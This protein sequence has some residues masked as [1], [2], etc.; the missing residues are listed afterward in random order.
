MSR[1][2]RNDSGLVGLFVTGTDTGVGKT[3]VTC[4]I[5]AALRARGMDVGVYKP[6]ETGCRRDGDCLTGEDCGR[7]VAAAGHAQTVEETASYL[8]ELPAAPLVAAEAAGARIDPARIVGG[9][10]RLGHQH[11]FVLVEGA[12]GLLVPIAEGYAYLDLARELALPVVVVVGSRLGCINHALLTLGALERVELE[13]AGWVLNAMTAATGDAE[14]DAVTATNRRTIA[15]FTAQ[16]DL[17]AFP[18]VEPSARDDPEALGRLAAEHLDL[19]GL[20]R[21]AV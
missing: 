15:R 6:A 20:L 7:L 12:G 17:G 21:R 19:D 16:R 5:T 8:F 14:A 9:V 10:E 1:D 3:L 2:A 13:T 18:F 11:E 4:A